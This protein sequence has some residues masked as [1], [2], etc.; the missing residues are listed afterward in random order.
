[1]PFKEAVF[2]VGLTVFGTGSYFV[3]DPTK[4][5]WAVSMI[6]LGLVAFGYSIYTY[7]HPNAPKLPLWAFLL[8]L[9]WVAIGFDYYD[10]HYLPRIVVG[11]QALVQPLITSDNLEVNVRQWLDD[12]HLSVKRKDDPDAFFSFDIV[13][14]SGGMTLRRAKKLDK[15]LVLGAIAGLDEKLMNEYSRLSDEQKA[16]LDSDLKLELARARLSFEYRLPGPILISNAIPITANLTEYDVIKNISD[17][18]DAILLVKTSVAANLAR[19]GGRRT[20]K[21]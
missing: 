20:V 11:D 3:V 7:Y 14:P 21:Q 17:F 1:M 13:G 10:R 8:L 18:G 19:I 6:V 9:T 4:R 16:E 2:W 5:G 15:Y 12:F